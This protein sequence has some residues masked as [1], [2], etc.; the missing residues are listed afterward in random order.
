MRE[1][2]GAAYVGKSASRGHSARQCSAAD[3][4]SDTSRGKNVCR[5][6]GGGL[7]LGHLGLARSAPW[8]LG[9]RRVG[10]GAVHRSLIQRHPLSELQSPRTPWRHVL[11]DLRSCCCPVGCYCYCVPQLCSAFGGRPEYAQTYTTAE[12][13]LLWQQQTGVKE[14][15]IDGGVLLGGFLV[16]PSMASKLTE[17]I[18]LDRLIIRRAPDMT[19]EHVEAAVAS[20]LSRE[21]VIVSD[22]EGVTEAGVV[23]AGAA[24]KGVTVS[25]EAPVR[26]EYADVSLSNSLEDIVAAV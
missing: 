18:K 24:A 13:P 15:V 22:C 17:R 12:D 10:L 2:G 14:M 1:G 25:L 8:V 20:R 16:E 6:A 7:H 26:D 5:G 4:W 23:V 21:I 3:P 9:S 19:D 11:T